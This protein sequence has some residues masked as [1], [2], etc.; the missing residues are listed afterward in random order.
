MGVTLVTFFDYY[1]K[2]EIIQFGRFYDLVREIISVRRCGKYPPKANYVMRG[3]LCVTLDGQIL[4]L[5]VIILDVTR[6]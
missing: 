3:I 5:W 2:S 1:I 4:G 6:G